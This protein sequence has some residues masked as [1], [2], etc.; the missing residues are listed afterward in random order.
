MECHDSQ[1]FKLHS[2]NQNT[3][4]G[5]PISGATQQNLKPSPTHRRAP[6]PRM[7]PVLASECYMAHARL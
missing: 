2:G 5:V 4:K 6:Q 1:P 3:P 7:S